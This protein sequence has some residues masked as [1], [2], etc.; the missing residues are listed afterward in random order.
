M[1]NSRLMVNPATESRTRYPNQRITILHLRDQRSP[2]VAQ[3]RVLMAILMPRT[4]HL[5]KQ[6]DIDVLAFVPSNAFLCTDDRNTRT[7]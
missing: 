7:P 5:P 2:R 6:L 4:N 3:T 1:I